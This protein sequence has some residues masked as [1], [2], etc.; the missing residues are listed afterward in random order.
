MQAPST[1]PVVVRIQRTIA[2]LKITLRYSDTSVR[3]SLKNRMDLFVLIIQTQEKI[4]G[5]QVKKRD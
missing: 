2:A 5:G 3:T 4:G 1:G